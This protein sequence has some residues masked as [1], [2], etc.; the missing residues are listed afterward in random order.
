MEN[1][2]LRTT[3][4]R[5]FSEVSASGVIGDPE[6]QLSF[7]YIRVSSSGQAEEGRS[8]LPRQLAHVDEKAKELKLCIPLE[9]VYCDDH[10]GFE[11]RE[12]PGLQALLAEVAKPN[13]KAHHLIIEYLDRLSRNAKW[14]QGFLLD[15]FAEHRVKIHFW[16]SFSSEIERA[17]MG[18]ISEQGMRQ[19]IERMTQG[20]QHKAR[21]GRITAKTP[22][23]GYSFVDSE[24]R[25]NSD[26]ASRFRKDTYYVI[27]PDEA[28]VLQE[29]YK[30]IISGE[31][32]YSICNDFNGRGVPTPK[33]AQYWETG[34]LSK[35]LKNPLYSG[36][37]VANRFYNYQEWSESAQRI[38]RKQRVRPK[39]EW[40]MV[41]V[42][43]IISPREW[44]ETQ[45]ALKRNLKSSRRHAKQP[46]LLQGFLRCARCGSKFYCSSGRDKGKEALRYFY[47]CKTRHLQPAIREHLSCNSP[48]I[49]R[50]AIDSVVWDAIC[51]VII[52]PELI[53]RYL[54]DQAE[55]LINGGL[56]DQLAYIERE[57]R[58]CD[59]EENQWDRAFADEIISLDEYKD[60]KNSVMA[61]KKTLMEEQ[62]KL[63]V[64][65]QDA[66]M[67]IAQKDIVRQHILDIQK[68]GFGEN[69][70]LEEKR[71]ILA[72]LIDHIVIDT[73]E[74]WFR[75]EGVIQGTYN[76]DQ[77]ASTNITSKAP[78]FTW[79]SDPSHPRTRAHGQYRLP[80][81]Q[82]LGPRAWEPN[83][84][85]ANAAPNWR[86]RESGKSRLPAPTT[87]RLRRRPG[88]KCDDSPGAQPCSPS[89]IRR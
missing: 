63:V 49:R 78:Q 2:E 50:E 74:R 24:G 4:G 37:Y 62:A 14:H 71:R 81:Q 86:G 44:Q 70:P 67:L 19:E 33:G 5:I 6:G 34:S 57:V 36:E 21:S 1:E 40:I 7:A 84:C 73:E 16:K 12:R 47:G 48:F 56:T 59:R 30:R 8:G 87:L 42:P 43:A 28:R 65:V 25:P 75:L 32:L 38:V 60:K 53:V 31:S 41:P 77:P 79:M 23:Y 80:D 54:E 39:E 51:Q 58:K 15:L 83:A 35:L 20:T 26:P 82:I 10:S 22:A 89:A 69:L 11:F 46:F 68:T 29:I 27:N 55:K 17:V 61:R 76:L 9:L 88:Q 18:A 45:D 64:E 66:Q 3:I 72:L 13:A 52:D 85:P